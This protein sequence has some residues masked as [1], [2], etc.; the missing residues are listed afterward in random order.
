[1]ALS[2]LFARPGRQLP[3]SEAPL[4]IELVQQQAQIRGAPPPPAVPPTPQPSPAAAAASPTPPLPEAK[5]APPPASPPPPSPSPTPAAT[6]PAPR[7]TPTPSEVNLG[8]AM[9]DLDPLTVTGTNVVPAAPDARYRN[10]P[11]HYPADAARIGAEGTV[12]V[13]AHIAPSGRPASVGIVTSSGNADL[14]AE[15][16]RSV[17]RWHFKPAFQGGRSVPFDYVINIRFALNNR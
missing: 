16:Q 2:L 10:E 13:V 4:E 3:Q 5:A 17:M 7:A 12:Q 6:P 15:A 8:N 11:P 9:R 1:M 14:D